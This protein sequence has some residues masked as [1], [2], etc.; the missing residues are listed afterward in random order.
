M[1]PQHSEGGAEFQNP[2][3]GVVTECGFK[4]PPVLE[5]SRY[6]KKNYRRGPTNLRAESRRVAR[7]KVNYYKAVPWHPLDT[8]PSGK[9]ED[10]R[11]TGY[12]IPVDV[13]LTFC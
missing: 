9:T 6:G 2:L 12:V 13:L 4:K 11:R 5:N 10:L 8:R 7:E 1:T 3:P